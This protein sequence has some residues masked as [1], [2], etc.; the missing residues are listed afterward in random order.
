MRKVWFVDDEPLIVQGLSAIMDW[1]RFNF[2]VAG[3][4]RDGAEALEQLRDEPV[5]LLITDIMMPKMNGLELIQKIKELHPHTRFIIL[6]GYEEFDYVKRGIKLGIQNYILKPINLEELEST[7]ELIVQDWQREERSRYCQEEDWKVLRSNVLQR[8]VNGTIEAPELEQRAELLGFSLKGK[9]FHVHVVRVWDPANRGLGILETSCLPELLGGFLS[10]CCGAFKNSIV[11]TDRDDDLVVFLPHTGGD[12]WREAEREALYS[13][14]EQLHSRTGLRFWCEPGA[15]D[16]KGNMTEV[17]DSYIHAKRQ[18]ETRLI[19]NGKLVYCGRADEVKAIP[20]PCRGGLD[21]LNKRVIE[22]DPEKIGKHIVSVLG[23][24]SDLDTVSRQG[25]L[26]LAVQLM[27][28][29]KEIANNTDYSDVFTPLQRIY[30]LEELQQHVLLVVSRTLD[31]KQEERPRYS[32]HVSYLLDQVEHHYAEELSLKTLSQRLQLHP[33]YIGQLFLQEVGATFS[34]YLNQYR[35]EKAARLLL[36]TDQKTSDI[37]IHVGY[38]D[39]SYFYRQFKKYT[40][41]SPTNMRARYAKT[42]LLTAEQELDTQKR[43]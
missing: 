12:R 31:R 8:W 19:T 17:P 2:E 9:T 6:S 3:T 29:V 26:N 10:E 35:I 18:L 28:A 42:S 16:A 22:G 36:H 38:M 33:N 21:E 40:G 11:F 24:D 13:C 23:A 41:I 37:A 30:T 20:P 4:A 15:A 5:D 14:L 34:D 27:L 7:I 32:T 25:Y 1:S 39:S 43:H